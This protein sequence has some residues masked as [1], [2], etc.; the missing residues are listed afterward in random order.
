MLDYIS[1]C[2]NNSSGCIWAPCR[3]DME[4]QTSKSLKWGG[5][6]MEDKDI[7][8]IVIGIIGLVLTAISVG[9]SLV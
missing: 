5:A 3:L 1:H 8:L 6:D 4:A 7:I 9:A 2:H